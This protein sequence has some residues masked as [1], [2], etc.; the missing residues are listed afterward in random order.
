MIQKIYLMVFPYAEVIISTTITCV[1]KMC[2]KRFTSVGG[3]VDFRDK[4]LLIQLLFNL[5]RSYFSTIN[6]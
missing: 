3:R 4:S 6:L 2:H 5:I 1:H